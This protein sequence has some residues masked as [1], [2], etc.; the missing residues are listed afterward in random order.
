MKAATLLQILD[1]REKI[2]EIAR[3][4]NAGIHITLLWKHL[5]FHTPRGEK[6][7]GKRI[8]T[9][10]YANNKNYIKLRSLYSNSGKYYLITL[11]V[12][13]DIINTFRNYFTPVWEERADG[14]LTGTQ[15]GAKVLYDQ[16]AIIRGGFLE[17]GAYSTDLPTKTIETALADLLI[18]GT[19]DEICMLKGILTNGE[20]LICRIK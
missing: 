4:Y 2:R 17:L 3:E 18:K 10:G 12:A 7:I 8:K 15:E 1:D 20:K 14:T 9:S 16:P 13:S 19:D 11:Q 5:S 6:R